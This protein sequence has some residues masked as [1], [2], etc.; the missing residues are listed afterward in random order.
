MQSS[1]IEEKLNKLKEFCASNGLR[2]TKQREEIY[3]ELLK[4]KAHPDAEAVFNIVRTKIPNISLDT[5]YRTIV[6]LEELG[7]IFRVDN[8]LSK[9]RFDADKTPHHHFICTKCGEVYDILINQN[10][11]LN[12]PEN[13]YQFGEV[14]EINL[15]IK[16]VCKKCIGT[17][18]R[19]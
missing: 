5:V 3:T 1:M 6:S 15:Q 4:S 12:I 10:E 7:F 14:K 2:Y 16:G 8:Q 18:R 13:S 9:A 17:E 11:I 19:K